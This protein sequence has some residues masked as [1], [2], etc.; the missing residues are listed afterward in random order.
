MGFTTP[1][2]GTNKPLYIL[3]PNEKDESGEKCDPH[4]KVVKRENGVS[5]VCDNQKGLTAVLSGVDVKTRTFTP[6]GKPE[7]TY[8]EIAVKLFDDTANYLVS[9]RFRMDTRS[10]FN[11]LL[12]AKIGEA[13][14]LEIY[15]SKKG[16]LS[17]SL[18][19]A[20]DERIE[21]KFDKEQV[22]ERDP[23]TVRG[24]VK[25]YDYTAID[26]FYKKALL[27]A[28][29]GEKT[30]S[31]DTESLESSDKEEKDSIPF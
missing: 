15:K 22:P 1:K 27:E 24:E 2:S 3:T 11:S 13:V 8:E 26:E 6:K 5:E 20:K 12:N 7:I 25:S 29:G 4:F 21:W 30:D 17:Y 31:E 19:N 10:L 23:V 28:F 16:Y 18:K 9:L 14:T